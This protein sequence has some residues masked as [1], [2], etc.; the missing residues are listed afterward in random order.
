VIVRQWSAWEVGSSAG[1][2]RWTQS[3]IDGMARSTGPVGE[4]M[5]RQTASTAK[6]RNVVMGIGS[7][8]VPEG[9]SALPWSPSCG[10][11]S[12]FSSIALCQWQQ[13]SIQQSSAGVAKGSDSTGGQYTRRESCATLLE[14]GTRSSTGAERARREFRREE[15]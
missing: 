8:A 9:R 5:H 12:T 3:A 7:V 13:Q 15:T 4:D 1:E 6:D 2:G 10:F 11:K 14:A